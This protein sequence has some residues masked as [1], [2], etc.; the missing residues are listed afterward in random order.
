MHC[1]EPVYCLPET[2]FKKLRLAA[3]QNNT[4]LLLFLAC[5]L[6][7]VSHFFHSRANITGYTSC[8][9]LAKQILSK[10]HIISAEYLQN[11]TQGLHP[12]WRFNACSFRLMGQK[13]DLSTA[14]L[15]CFL[16]W[17]F[18]GQSSSFSPALFPQCILM[19]Q[20]ISF[21]IAGVYFM[22]ATVN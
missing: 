8:V 21:S 20:T 14:L 17:I 2:A 12:I 9:L 13:I 15:F 7:H 10:R 1:F 16:T 18:L 22:S 6:G 11:Q 4:F 3:S 5:I 19:I